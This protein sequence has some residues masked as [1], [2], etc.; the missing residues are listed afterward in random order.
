MPF[1]TARKDLAKASPS[2]AHSNTGRG[3]PTSGN[4]LREFLDMLPCAAFIERSGEVIP[5]NPLAC[6]IMGTDQSL[7]VS[8]VFVRGYPAPG[9]EHHHRFDGVVQRADGQSLQISGAVQRFPVAGGAARLVLLMEVL[10]I[11]TDDGA[12]EGVVAPSV[13][14]AA[15]SAPEAANSY[16]QDLFDSS[17]EPTIIVHGTLILSANREFL[18]LFDY[19]LAQCVG[20]DTN[21]LITPEGRHHESEM[22]L[23]TVLASGRATIETVRRNSRGEELDVSLNLTRVRLGRDRMGLCITFRDIR[24]QK[25]TEARLQHASLHD[26]LT[27][28]A[29]RVLFL[30]RVTLTMARFKRRPDRPFA[31]VFLDV[32][33]FKHVNDT[34][35]HAAGDAIL[36]AVT[37]RLRTS[38]RPQD[39]VARFGGDEFALLLDEVSGVEDIGRLAD[40][41]QAE[42]RQPVDVDGREVFVSASMGIAISSTT[43]QGVDEIMRDA[44]VAMYAA[45]AAGKARHEFFG[46][47]VPPVPALAE[48]EVAVPDVTEELVARRT[49]WPASWG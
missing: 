15:A 1:N 39:T 21:D 13:K 43:Y 31:V 49:P 5:A 8:K 24:A 45:K 3:A 48:P 47:P 14:P 38:L 29:N 4:A 44:D 26:P 25:Q 46:A 17:P 40:R 33:H 22:L 2:D 34:H 35:G 19:T 18:H 28:L 41:I 10:S 23:H 7:Q 20:A 27:G 12:T 36:L 9:D 32:D 42:L 16:L 30:D 37:A 11:G 6:K